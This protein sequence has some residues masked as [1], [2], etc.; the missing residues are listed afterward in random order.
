[1]W[2]SNINCS[3]AY[4]HN[5][6]LAHVIHALPIDRL[7][8]SHRM[9][10]VSLLCY[11]PPSSVGSLQMS[12]N[13]RSPFLRTFSNA[14]SAGL[15]AQVSHQP[16]CFGKLNSSPWTPAQPSASVANSAAGQQ[17]MNTGI[18]LEREWPRVLQ[19]A[20]DTSMASTV[21]ACRLLRTLSGRNTVA[22]R[23]TLSVPASTVT[24]CRTT[25]SSVPKLWARI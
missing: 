22:I 6:S 11:R 4:I 7:C 9:M 1:M 8:P 19:Q 24:E 25:S 23:A 2:H 20:M 10:T 13:R 17:V 12:V 15:T 3:I 21:Q 16:N 5:T 14:A 18:A